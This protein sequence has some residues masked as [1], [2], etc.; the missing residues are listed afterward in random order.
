MKTGMGSHERTREGATNEWLTPR[1]ILDDLGPFDLDPCAPVE[2]PWDIATHHY[3]IENDGLSFPWDGFVWLNPPY[4]PHAGLWLKRL[5]EHGNGL[6]L[7]FA[8]TE[9]KAWSEHIWNGADAIGFLEG[10]L[11]FCRVDGTVDMHSN[12]GAPSALVAYG[13]DATLRL[14]NSTLPM[15]IVT[16]WSKR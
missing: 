11:R 13:R 7:I 2:R 12:A 15:H 8:R 1:Y 14:F 10:R 9:T 6:A 5:K 16:A 4:G 3:T